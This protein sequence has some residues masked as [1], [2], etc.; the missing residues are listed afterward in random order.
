MKIKNITIKRFR[1]I[2]EQVVDDIGNA[3]VLIGKNNSGKSAILT[4]IRLLFGDYIP[5]D[6]D[7]YKDSDSFEID[8]GFVISD[9]YISEFFLDKKLGFTKF[10]SSLNE[11]NSV[12]EGTIFADT[13]FNDFKTERSSVI[14]ECYD[15]VSTRE[16][17][18]TIW[19]KAFKKKFSIVDEFLSIKVLCNKNDLRINYEIDGTANRD[20]PNLFPNVAFIDD[21]RYFEE[22]ETGKAKT[23]TSSL[24]SYVLKT[25]SIPLANAISCDKCNRTDCE[26]T[27]INEIRQ[28][29]PL[30]LTIEDLQKLINYKT[31]NSAESITRSIS[32][33]FQNNY[34]KNFTVNI[35]ATSNIDKSF[36]ITT[37]IYDP[38]L[39]AEIDLSNVGAGVRSIYILSL[40][41]SFQA[42]NSKRTI[43]I[44]EEPELYLHPELQKTM[45]DTLAQ[46]SNS[47]Q[48]VFT[49]HSPI[50]LRAFSNSDIRKVRL[51]EEEYFSI[52]ENTTIDDV[53]NEIGYSSQDVLNADFI[54]FV[55]G[56]DDTKVIET[57]LTKYYHID[58]ERLLII[59]TNSCL[60]IGFY[61]TLKFLR[62][63]TLCENFAILRDLDTKLE[64]DVIETLR[65]QLTSNLGNDYAATATSH[66]FV[67]KYSS[68]E[69]YLFS[70]ELLVSH[71][72]YESVDTVYMLLHEKLNQ[73]KAKSC[74][75]FRKHNQGNEER[76]GEFELRYDE[77][78]VNVEQ[79]IEWVKKNIRG[80]FYFDA[81]Q[82][83]R[84]SYED[85]VLE[86]P[87]ERFSDILEFFDS[88]DYFANKINH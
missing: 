65:N 69:G 83:K 10:P 48:V 31:H 73:G 63:T 40:L 71:N 41:Q 35:K 62:R 3:L 23:I 37:K 25:Q 18:E 67:T 28:K 53:L 34:Q 79:N 36:S 78:I 17:F 38:N 1:S 12:K 42:M 56:P 2:K 58:L 46:I 6:K 22:E 49:S 80:H 9:D 5:K 19:M 45:A 8:A 60:N 16:R 77:M 24:F 82:S 33:R 64:D 14:E 47:C 15:D 74:N 11:F 70:P 55:E 66:L 88:I 4:A 52:V 76:I 75:Y 13:T 84:I 39:N 54:I 32:E 57:L 50:M 59:D 26:I 43:F 87:K 30:D 21:T 86:L 61:A 68:I 81:T 20:I 7:F 27:C 51:N 85:Y 72:V 29:N 44:V